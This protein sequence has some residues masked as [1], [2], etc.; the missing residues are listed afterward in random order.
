RAS[1]DAYDSEQPRPQDHDLPPTSGSAD[2]DRNDSA[3]VSEAI[4]ASER[5]AMEAERET[6]DRYVAAW[7][8]GRVGEV[9]DTRIT[10]VQK[11]GSFATIIGSGG[12]GSVPVSVSGAER[13]AYD[14]KAQV[15]EGESSGEQ[16]AMGMI[17]K[18]RSAEANPSTGASKFEP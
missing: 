8:A 13:F 11:F 17:L 12:D 18:S 9:F 3:R 15:S 6:I 1:V 10:G 14:E 2:R 4:S 5:R 16:F 7:S